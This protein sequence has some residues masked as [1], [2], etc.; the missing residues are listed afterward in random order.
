MKMNG[1][2]FREIVDNAYA[3]LRRRIDDGESNH[4]EFMPFECI[5]PGN[6]RRCYH[7]DGVHMYYKIEETGTKPIYPKLYKFGKEFGREL[8]KADV[9]DLPLSQLPEKFGGCLE[10]NGHWFFVLLDL[11]GFRLNI[12]ELGNLICLHFS[13]DGLFCEDLTALLHHE[14]TKI[15]ELIE[16]QLEKENN[17]AF[18]EE[19][20]RLMI[21]ALIY[22]TTGSPDLREYKPPE[23]KSSEPRRVRDRI[24]AEYGN[25][26]CVLVSWGWKKPRQTHT[27][28]WEVQGHFWWAPV[29]QGRSRRELRWREGHTR[30]HQSG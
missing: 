2:S 27:S 14:F 19:D 26:E 28:E 10:I 6:V 7:E 17:E 24:I 12:T 18:K 22:V 11:I 16:F 20:F 30:A 4:L 1:L 29:G 8:A 21:N 5:L 23:R 13:K 3:L 15:D 9:S 25:D